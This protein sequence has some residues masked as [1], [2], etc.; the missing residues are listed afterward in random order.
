MAQ[1]DNATDSDSEERGFESLR[2]GQSPKG[3]SLW[4]FNYSPF[5]IHSSLKNAFATLEVIST[6]CGSAYTAEKFDLFKKISGAKYLL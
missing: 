3:V 1:L 5:T 6:M 4:D 2:A